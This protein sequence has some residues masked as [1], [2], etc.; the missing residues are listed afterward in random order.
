MYYTSIERSWV[1]LF[2]YV[3]FGGKCEDFQNITKKIIYPTPERIFFSLT[4]VLSIQVKSTYY[5]KESVK[6]SCGSL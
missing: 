4:V 3:G 2:S 1:V 6:V 5:N